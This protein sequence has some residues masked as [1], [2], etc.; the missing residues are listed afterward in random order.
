MSGHLRGAVS[1]ELR[2]HFVAFASAFLW[3]SS[4]PVTQLL[5]ASWDPLPLAAVRISVAALFLLAGLYFV[6]YGGELRRAPWPDVLRVGGIGI[7]CGALLLV[8]GQSLASAVTAAVTTAAMPAISAL[9]GCI[10]A[11][12]MP[13]L[14]LLAAVLL[15]VV[16][17][18][19]AVLAGHG[20]NAHFRGGELL[21]FAA[22]VLWVWYSR[23]AMRS[24]GGLSDLAT[25]ALTTFAGGLLLVLAVGIAALAGIRGLAVDWR[26]TN[27]ALLLWLACIAVALPVALWIHGVRLLGITLCSIHLNLVPL[28]AA[29]TSSLAL[30][31]VPPMQWLGA[32]LVVAAALL[33][34]E[35]TATGLAR[36]RPEPAPAIADPPRG[37]A[38]HRHPATKADAPRSP[39]SA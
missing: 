32:A 19:L 5:L 13:G 18:V 24:L 36:P 38:G 21:V 26:P 11:R 30:E 22:M 34:R 2:G 39:T 6:G 16:G 12:R 31:R 37:A 23:A 9:A 27:V 8:W 28:Y 14:R 3:A 20:G 7:G 1:S 15:A 35:K 33:A 17:G 25:A 29:L 10:E 4:F